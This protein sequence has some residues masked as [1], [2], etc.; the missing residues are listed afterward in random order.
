M[1]L[2]FSTGNME[3]RREWGVYLSR[4]RLNLAGGNDESHDPMGCGFAATGA[5]S[6][7]AR[8]MTN[9]PTELL[10]TLVAVVD[11][12]SFTKAA[13]SLGVTQPAVSAQ[14]KRLQGLLGTDLLDKSAPGVSL[15]SAGELVVNYARRLL[16]INDQI[17][18]IA[19][20]RPAAKKI[21]V[22]ATGDFTSAGTTLGLRRAFLKRPDLRFELYMA[23]S[24]A[25][26]KDVREGEADLAVCV[27]ATLPSLETRHY[28]TEPLVW[29]RSPDLNIDPARP[30]PLISYDHDRLINRVGMSALSQAGRDYEKVFIG[31]TLASLKVA[32]AAGFGVLPLPRSYSDL[33]GIERWENGPLP[34]LP[35]VYCCVYIRGGAEIEEREQIADAIAS[36]FGAQPRGGKSAESL[37][38][39]SAALI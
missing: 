28:W 18:D 36:A 23:N 2:D 27:S 5:L 20:P 39:T 1:T 3:Y 11:L 33:H 10:R 7:D 34:R 8:S 38:R 13:Q 35:D 15:T 17:L 14:I 31:A 6:R 12:R 32:V 26:L 25:L 4:T 24:E 37:R 16:S 22:G 30:V 19:G 29:L 9:I 21:R